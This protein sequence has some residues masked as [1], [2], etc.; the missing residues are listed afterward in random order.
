MKNL[1]ILS[2]CSLSLFYSCGSGDENETTVEDEPKLVLPYEEGGAETAKIYFEGLAGHLARVDEKLR[3]VRELD[4]MDASVDSIRT[5]LDSILFL[6]DQD[7]KII[8]MYNSKTWPE[9]DSLQKLTLAWYDAVEMLVN[10]HFLALAEAFS[11]PDVSWTDA[12]REKY[13]AYEAAYIDVFYVADKKWV[14]FQ[15]V[16]TAANNLTFDNEKPDL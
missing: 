4:D 3:Y 5:E 16:F 15:D 1:V 6:A 14:D 13:A 9:K 10:D 8:M 7:K 2:L 12:D 11:R